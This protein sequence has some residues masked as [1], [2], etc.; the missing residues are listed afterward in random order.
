MDFGALMANVDQYLASQNRLFRH[1]RIREIKKFSQEDKP[2]KL[3][4][5]MNGAGYIG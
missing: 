3:M 2:C 4:G 1:K 5:P